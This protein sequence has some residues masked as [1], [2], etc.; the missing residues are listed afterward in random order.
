MG[1]EVKAQDVACHGDV[2]HAGDMGAGAA[3]EEPT[4]DIRKLQVIWDELQ[5]VTD[6]SEQIELFR[7][8]YD[9]HMEH[10]WLIGIIGHVPRPIVVNSKL[11]N[12]PEKAICSWTIMRYLGPARIEQI[13]FE[14]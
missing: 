11:R 9:L 5:T 13:F 4:G 10:C 12:I 6:Q 3:G 8:L 7:Q 2:E 1:L 14:S